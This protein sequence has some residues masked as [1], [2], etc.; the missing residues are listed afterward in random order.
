MSECI[1]FSI[2]FG[3]TKNPIDYGNQLAKQL[4]FESWRIVKVRDGID[5]IDNV[6]A[7]FWKL[8]GFKV[9]RTTNS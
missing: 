5:I 7:E 1:N 2:A 8:E 3:D 9:E 6:V 4:D